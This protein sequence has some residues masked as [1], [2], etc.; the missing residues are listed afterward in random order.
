LLRT[1]RESG[2]QQVYVTHGNSDGLARYLREVEGISAEPL[3]G[4]FAAERGDGGD[5]GDGRE[6]AGDSA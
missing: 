1:V 6:G 3:A 2:A 4:A 5:G